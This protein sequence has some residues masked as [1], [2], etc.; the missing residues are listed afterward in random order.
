VT[1][2]LAA[3]VG[4]AVIYFGGIAQLS[5]LSGSVARAVEVGVVPFAL[6]DV[7]KAFIAAAISGPRRRPTAQ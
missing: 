2:W 6:L 1:R 5:V 4:I 3:I 7:V